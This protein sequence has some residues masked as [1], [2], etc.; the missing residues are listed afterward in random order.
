MALAGC[1][2]LRRQG[3][4]PVLMTGGHEGPAADVAKPLQPARFLARVAEGVARSEALRR[5]DEL[6]EQ[7]REQLRTIAGL[8]TLLR[9]GAAAEADD[10]RAGAGEGERLEV[11]RADRRPLPTEICEQLSVREQEVLLAFRDNPRLKAVADRLA[12]S[13]NTVRNH[14]KSI[15]RKLEVNSQAVLLSRL[16]G[17]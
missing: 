4:L 3:V 8:R 6:E 10:K 1:E 14:F 7:L 2:S 15:Y 13:P 17:A 16:R 5:I 9:V 12:I 11:L